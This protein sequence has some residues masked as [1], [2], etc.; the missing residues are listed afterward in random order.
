MHT[1]ERV[2]A[3]I[4]KLNKLTSLGEIEWAVRDTP[5]SISRGSDDYISLFMWAAYKGQKF[6]LFEHRYQAYEGEYDRFY[7]TKRIVLAILDD[8]GRAIWETTSQTPA[9][10]DLYET[11]RR[12]VSNI[13]GLLDE[14]LEDDGDEYSQQTHR[15]QSGQ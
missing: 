10:F 13:D 15:Q 12:K 7:W 11:A 4:V 8:E 14:L 2:A 3:L 1:E 9:L 5:Q 6:G